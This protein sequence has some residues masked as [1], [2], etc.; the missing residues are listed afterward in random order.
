MVQHKFIFIGGLHRSGTWLVTHYLEEHSQISRLT[1][2]PI[3]SPS[4]IS[5][6]KPEGQY[7]QTVY[8][9]DQ[10][11]GGVGR[12][13]FHP[14]A[15]LT[16][17]SPMVTE[18]NRTKLYSEW[19]RYWDTNKL[20]LLEKTPANLLRSRFLQAL[21]PSSYF[22]FLIRHPI[23]VAL[24][25]Q[26]WTG[27]SVSSLVDHWLV[28]YETLLSDLKY[29][30]NH[31]TVKYEEFIAD[32]KGTLNRMSSFL[33]IAS[34]PSMQ[35]KV[36]DGNEAYFRIWKRALNK[37]DNVGNLTFARRVR[38]RLMPYFLRSGHPLTILANEAQTIVQRYDS[39]VG[40]FGYSLE[41]PW[42]FEAIDIDGF[43]H[44]AESA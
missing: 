12:L 33:G 34:E 4:G 28:C 14:E 21:F 40:S 7:L 31:L 19:S 15:H 27:T 20:F 25:Q 32:P 1:G 5:A 6:T 41:E 22:I 16:E 36:Y 43:Q 37:Q 9:Q 26:K 18:E 42:K 29:L 13:G 30:D 8:P 11:Y 39:R 44:A 17:E 38:N 23:A 2:A 10:Y 24:A 35:G 3:Q